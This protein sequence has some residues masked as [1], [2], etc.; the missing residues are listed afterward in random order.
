MSD[1]T[2]PHSGTAPDGDPTPH[3]ADDSTGLEELNVAGI[4]GTLG[5]KDNFEPEESEG[6]PE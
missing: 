6:A 1:A 5:E 2:T 4:G 3:G